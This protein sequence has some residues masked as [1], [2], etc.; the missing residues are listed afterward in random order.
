[1]CQTPVDDA[2]TPESQMLMQDVHPPQ[3]YGTADPV[4]NISLWIDHKRTH[5]IPYRP[6]DSLRVND[7]P[8]AFRGQNIEVMEVAMHQYGHMIL[9]KEIF[10]RMFNSFNQLFLQRTRPAVEHFSQAF[11]SIEPIGEANKTLES[12]SL[13]SIREH[14]LRV[15]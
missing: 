3:H 11:Q 6:N 5:L 9:G 15:Q 13:L 7:Q 2:L 8:A 1:M 12:D 14:T 10:G 4:R